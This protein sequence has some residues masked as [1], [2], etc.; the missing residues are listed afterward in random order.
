M[1]LIPGRDCLKIFGQLFFNYEEM[2]G[3]KNKQPG[4]EDRSAQKKEGNIFDI[5]FESDNRQYKGW[6]TPSEEISEPGTPVSFHVV[7]NNV[8]FGYLSFPDCKWISNEE[9]PSVLVK[10]AGKQIEKHYQL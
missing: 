9:R 5:A 4:K 3:I 1:S 6:V 2:T 10:L 7:L 8:S